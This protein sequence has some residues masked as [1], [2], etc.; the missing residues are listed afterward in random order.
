MRAIRCLQIDP[1]RAVERTQFLVLFS[2]LG[3]YDPAL[4]RKTAYE[5]KF[6]FEYWAHAASYVLTEDYAIYKPHMINHFS[7]KGSWARRARELDAG[8]TMLLYNLACIYSLAG[9]IERA[10][11]CIEEAMRWGFSNADWLLH[12]SNL[13]VLRGE[14][15][16][17]AI[18]GALEAVK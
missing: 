6:L 11:E 13:A 3:K 15:R 4:L 8:D 1:L 12:D 14:P 18:V 5:E 10:I 16:F 7:G 17:T 9:E 2:R